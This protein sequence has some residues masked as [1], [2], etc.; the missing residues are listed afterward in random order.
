MLREGGFGFDL[1]ANPSSLVV[2]L[3]TANVVVSISAALLSLILAWVLYL[4]KSGE[5]MVVL[6]SF[7]LLLFGVGIGPLETLAQMW[8]EYPAFGSPI[9]VSLLLAPPFIALLFLFPGRRQKP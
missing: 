3:N 4:K 1:A 7:F 6:L 5:R 8:L 2:A 9:I